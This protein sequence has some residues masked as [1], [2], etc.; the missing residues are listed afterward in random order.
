[1]QYEAKVGTLQDAKARLED[2]EGAF[3]RKTYKPV[4]ETGRTK[5]II[6]KERKDVVIE[7]L[8]K[9]YGTVTIGIHGQEL[10]KY[11][12]DYHQKE[13]WRNNKGYNENPEW[14]QSLTQL[15]Q[16]R[17]YWAKN[18]EMKI[19]DTNADI[20]AAPIDPF[21]VEHH[22]QHFKNDIA[23]HVHKITHWPDKGDGYA[24]TTPEPKGHLRQLKW[25]EMEKLYRCEGED[26]LIDKIIK[27]AEAYENAIEDSAEKMQR[28][29]TLSHKSPKQRM[30]IIRGKT[31]SQ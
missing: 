8:T 16:N 25:S 13:W 22:T 18:D 2:R 1:M 9:K 6:D 12:E 5:A 10:P 30:S 24:E 29:V 26:R 19:A 15:R 14:G 23:P 3:L 7:N 21:K 11:S 27:N 17:Q 31:S 28:L 20:N 4:D